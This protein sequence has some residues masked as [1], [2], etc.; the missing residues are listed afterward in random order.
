MKLVIASLLLSASAFAS[1]IDSHS[2]P[3]S[4]PMSQSNDSFSLFTT[5]TRT[6][7]RYEQE[8]RTCFRTEL[9][10]Y[11]TVCD[12]LADVQRPM[13]GHEPG[14]EPREPG[15]EPNPRP[16]PVPPRPVPVCHQE[17]VYR[18]VPY[19]CY[20]TVRIPYEVI[21][22]Q[23]VSN[24]DVKITNN[25]SVQTADQCFV[26]FIANGD[27]V[28]STT[29]CN[30]LLAIA[31][32][33]VSTGYDRGNKIQNFNYDVTLYNKAE[34]LGAL[35]GG[36]AN[37]HMDGQKVV[38]ATGDLNAAKNFTLRIFVERRRFLKS[39]E[40]L[41]DRALAPNEFVSNGNTTSIDLGKLLGGI[42][43]SKKHKIKV[44]LDV[45][46]PAGSVLNT[47]VPSLHQESEI[48]VWDN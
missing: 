9:V 29:A 40:T 16:M 18:T 20:E 41:I 34:M 33:R 19:T 47:G 8:A 22:H 12:R 48:T 37:L 25:S 35:N 24:F 4:G 30:D 6:E 14:R 7:Y 32:S 36:L 43:T 17:P 23:T 31:N 26:N 5:Q 10:G 11:Q 27:Y 38:F 46:L 2:L 44:Q 15:R 13:P 21:D 3:V 45:S 39:D 28:S 1:T 42:N